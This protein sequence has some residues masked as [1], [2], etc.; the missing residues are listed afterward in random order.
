MLKSRL[1]KTLVL[2]QFTGSRYAAPVGSGLVGVSTQ[3]IEFQF[4]KDYKNVK[5]IKKSLKIH[6]K[7]IIK[8]LIKIKSCWHKE[9]RG[10][11]KFMIIH[12]MC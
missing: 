12:K 10:K 5:K 1:S 7:I 3:G 11:H 6:W 4:D 8:K 2:T 9:N